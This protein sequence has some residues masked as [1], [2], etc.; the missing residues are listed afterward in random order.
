MNRPRC[1][2]GEYYVLTANSKFTLILSWLGQH[3]THY[4][5]HLNRTRFEL[6]TTSKQHTEFMLRYS[7]CVA[8]VDPG[9]DLVTGL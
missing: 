4:E 1:S 9:A 8:A 5:V 3:N 7:E 2:T 6:D